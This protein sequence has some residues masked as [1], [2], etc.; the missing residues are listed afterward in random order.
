M[1]A[2]IATVRNRFPALRP[3]PRRRTAA[4]LDSACMSLVPDRV[5][6][7]MQEYYTEYPGCAGRSVHRFSEEV[8]VRYE[9]ARARFAGFFRAP[10]GPS[11]VVFLRNATEA[12]NLVAHGIDWKRGDEVLVS[13]QEHNSNLVPWQ[14]LAA[15]RGTRLRFVRLPEDRPFD[16]E[17]FEEALARRPRL[18]SLFHASNLDG[19]LLPVAEIVERAHDRGALVLLDGCQAAPHARVDLRK[20]AADFYAIS[21][22]KMLGPTG[23]GAL[24]GAPERLDELAPTLLGGETV[25]WTTLSG[26]ALRAPPHRFE[27]GLQNYAGVLG[28]AEGLR[29][30]SEVGLDEVLAHDRALNARVTSELSSE[31]RVQR[32]GPEPVGERPSIFAFALDGV[33]ANDAALFLDEAYGVMV[34]SGRHCVHSW[35]EERRM[36]A[37]VRASFYLYNTEADV[38]RFI[39]GVRELLQRIPTTSGRRGAPR[40][41]ALSGTSAP[42]LASRSRPRPSRPRAAG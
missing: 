13:D 35:Y 41:G 15:T 28:A 19:R 17:V 11:S 26:H 2:R 39:Q 20:V 22:H 14:H 31:S 1:K 21:S 34:R 36:A 32:V 3:R 37:T 27:A 4:Y 38:D 5:L 10:G 40:G 30:L 25:E 12:I 9:A 29:F 7:A 6:S 33:D 8:S 16:S 24:I 18:V 23:T 42:R